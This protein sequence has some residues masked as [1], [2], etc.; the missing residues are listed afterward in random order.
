VFSFLKQKL[1]N[2]DGTTD[3]RWNFNIFLVDQQGT[4]AQRY[5]PGKTPYDDVKPK[6]EELLKKEE[7]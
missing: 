6:L 3:I 4:P 5:Q 2:D 1:P 7:K